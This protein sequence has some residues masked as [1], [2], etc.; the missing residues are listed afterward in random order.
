MPNPICHLEQLIV[1]LDRVMHALAEGI[2][3]ALR[4]AMDRAA[5]SKG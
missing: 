3:Q 5:K 1:Q 4:A 2:D